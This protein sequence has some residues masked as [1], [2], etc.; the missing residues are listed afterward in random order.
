MS[1]EL[2]KQQLRLRVKD[3]RQFKDWSTQSFE[4][5]RLQRVSGKRSN[6]TWDTQSWRLNL[7]KYEDF[8]DAEEE[9]IDL[10][11][12]RKISAA[13]YKEGIKLLHEWFKENG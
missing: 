7:S 2:K 3:L 13:Q 9:L 10:Y 6:D 11:E 4:E 1:V 12:K 8:D 5:G